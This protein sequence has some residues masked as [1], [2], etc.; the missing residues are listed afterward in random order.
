MTREEETEAMADEIANIIEAACEKHGC[1]KEDVRLTYNYDFPD[2]DDQ[3]GTFHIHV[4][5]PPS[6][7]IIVKVGDYDG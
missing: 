7:R 6:G 3:P 4:R 1:A 5:F 2:G